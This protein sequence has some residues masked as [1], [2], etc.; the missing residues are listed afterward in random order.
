[1]QVPMTQ[2]NAQSGRIS[3][4]LPLLAGLACAQILATLFV[5]RSDRLILQQNQTLTAA[6]WLAIPAGPAMAGLKTWGAAL[7]GGLFYTLTV[8]AGLTLLTWAGIILWQGVLRRNRL[9]AAALAVLWI[10]LLGAVNF[11]GLVLFPSLFVF[12]IP[13]CTGLIVIRRGRLAED[14]PRRWLWLVPVLSLVLLAGLWTT[15][16]NGDL[17]IAIRDNILLS[18][19]I[20]RKV[21]DFYY[22]NTLYAAQTFKSLSQK[23]IRAYQVQGLTDD[24]L[25]QRLDAVLSARDIFK[26]PAP[27]PADIRVVQL[28]DRWRLES[29]FGDSLDVAPAEFLKNPDRWLAALSDL[30]DR[31]AP[32]RRLTF[33]SLLV[34]FPVLMYILIYGFFYSGASCFLSRRSAVVIASGIC[35][36]IGI[37]FFI[38]M[39]KGRPAVVSRQ[40]IG[41]ALA[42]PDWHLC[43]AALHQ[44]EKQGLEI[45]RYTQYRSLLH[46]P[47][48]VERYWLARAMAVSR[49]ASTY[50]DLLA[51]MQDPHPNVVCQVYFAL[52]QRGNPAAIERIRNQIL[53]SDHWY[54]QWYGYHALRRL[55][56]HQRP[57]N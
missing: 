52:G 20:G 2:Y 17:F 27:G 30:S 7:R 14:G 38:A 3:A 56:W 24:R 1:M 55:G 42:S 47:L 21:N 40:E 6:G 25:A 13:L 44:I 4:A 35:L 9:G 8:G 49:S 33:Y 11:K 16:L 54:T 15:Q 39:L 36:V 12:F 19:S 29:S 32:L 48:V 50:A 45:S 22:R 28:R 51:M 10:A 41:S 53:Q 26:V 18:N 46:S 34:A 43:V 31:Y 37:G 5:W 57:S 23:T